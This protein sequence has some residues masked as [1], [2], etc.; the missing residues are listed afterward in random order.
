M[1]V[2]PWSQFPTL[3]PSPEV[4][5]ACLRECVSLVRCSRHAMGVTAAS[6]GQLAGAAYPDVA[7]HVIDTHVEPS[8]IE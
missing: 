3:F 1:S 7:R 4:V 2:S 6:R 8:F 5:N